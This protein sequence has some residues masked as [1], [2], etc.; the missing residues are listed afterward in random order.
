[1]MWF[2]SARL[3][4]I[5]I[6]TWPGSVS[7]TSPSQSRLLQYSPA[8]L[9]CCIRSLWHMGRGPAHRTP[10]WPW[11]CGCPRCPVRMRVCMP[12]R[13]K[14][15]RLRREP[16]CCAG[17]LSKVSVQCAACLKFHEV[18]V[19]GF[20]RMF[21]TTLLHRIVT[22]WFC[23]S[24]VVKEKKSWSAI[25]LLSLK[26]YSRNN[27]IWKCQDFLNSF[28]Q[29]LLLSLLLLLALIVALILGLEGA[30]IL[31]NLTD[32]KVNVSATVTLHCDAA[33]RP[34]PVVVWTKNNHTVVEG[35]GEMSE[36]STDSLL[37]ELSEVIWRTKRL[38]LR[39]DSEPAKPDSDDPACEERG[40]RSVHLHCM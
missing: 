24:L 6:A 32:Q 29:I 38:T 10:T 17:F 40:Q 26:S 33:G 12:V 28:K 4:N 11:S 27:K 8:A 21:R 3:T 5:S 9:W 20:V 34:N 2:F 16:A 36:M 19:E 1:M 23:S 35:S 18:S 37:Q 22:D 31:N 14:T 15:S 25:L 30:Q 7:A 13:W 39:C